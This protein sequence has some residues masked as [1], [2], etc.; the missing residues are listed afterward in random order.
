MKRIIVK[1]TLWIILLVAG[2][3]ALI[4]GRVIPFY[5]F[6]AS[7]GYFS[8]AGPFAKSP[9]GDMAIGDASDVIYITDEDGFVKSVFDDP[10]DRTMYYDACFDD[11]GNI[12][13]YSVDSDDDGNVVSQDIVKYDSDGKFICKVASLFGDEN[14]MYSRIKYIDG[15]LIGIMNCEDNGTQI[16]SFRNDAGNPEV[17]KYIECVGNCT[18]LGVDVFDGGEILVIYEDGSLYHASGLKEELTLVKEGQYDAVANPD[19]F[20]AYACVVYDDAIIVNDGIGGKRAIRIGSSS[21]EVVYSVISEDDRDGVYQNNI[22][23]MFCDRG[24]LAVSTIDALA[25]SDGGDFVYLDCV[26]GIPAKYYICNFL[27]KVLPVLGILLVLAGVFFLC[28]YLMKWKMSLLSRQLLVII[29]IVVLMFGVLLFSITSG[30]VKK[31]EQSCALSMMEFNEIAVSSID[32]KTLPGLINSESIRNGSVGEL[33]DKMAGLL[34]YND[35]DWSRDIVSKIFY[36]NSDKSGGRNLTTDDS[37]TYHFL[38]EIYFEGTIGEIMENP[39]DIDYIMQYDD[40]TYVSMTASSVESYITAITV[41]K[42]SEGKDVAF[43][44]TDMNLNDFITER[45]R[46]VRTIAAEALVFLALIIAAIVTVTYFTTGRLR[47]AENAIKEIASGNFDIRIG[48]LG[49]D[50]VGEICNSVNT[51]AV[52]LEE[53]F[54]EKDR[55]EKFYYKF[56]PEK[57]KELLNKDSFTDLR[58]GDAV[59]EE[60]T[61][62]FCDIRS[63]SLNSEMM[64]AKENFE[65]VNVIYGKAGPIIR[66]HGGFVDKYI[67]DA[68]MALFENADDAVAAGIEIYEAIVINPST[69]EEL[70]ARSINIGIG[71]HSGMARIGIVGEDERLSGTV[72]SNTVN[73]SSRLESLTKQYK[74]AMIISK[75]TLDRMSNP[76]SLNVRYLGMVQV[77]GVNEVEALYE[78]LDCLDKADKEK[79]SKNL[80]EFRDAIR[81]FHLGN[82][83]NAYDLMHNIAE[84]NR[85]DPVPAM[86]EEYIGARLKED[87]FEH[88]VF[89]FSRK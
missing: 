87:N 69:R 74:T 28:G 21:E 36:F 64:T 24:T 89:K 2:A 30:Y 29:P 56:V 65:F 13:V 43:L 75:E 81:E 5:N 35:S 44:V 84:A 54:E 14:G 12:Y 50:E 15:T 8:L 71:I 79:R 41:I 23:N 77:A 33:S 60:L 19:G 51:M 27:S 80:R 63:F 22:Y 67:G 68:V 82:I 48:K 18:P 37:T 85:E 34:C 73:L 10:K 32:S 39:A 57:F 62:L 11:E 3:I 72:I 26:L 4:G 17:E 42:N 55:N 83:A 6:A 66:K 59:S 9:N 86:Y 70:K 47:K 52:K 53:H 40:S 58:L 78:V 76:D 31:F 1:P 20:F 38:E 61:V 46:F 16:V 45:N 7:G 49:N 25:L 88:N